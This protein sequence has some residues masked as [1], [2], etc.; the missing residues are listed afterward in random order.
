MGSAVRAFEGHDSLSLQLKENSDDANTQNIPFAEGERNDISSAIYGSIYAVDVD[1]T[2]PLAFGYDKH[3]YSLKNSEVSYSFLDG[4]N[5]GKLSKNSKPLAGFS[6]NEATKL[7]SESLIFGM[8]SLGRGSVV[9]IVDN[10]LYRG[11]W[12]NGKLWVINAV[13]H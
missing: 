3:Y 12:E 4:G 13:F 9:Y 7:Q 8:E 2:H 10:P 1:T 6:G 5:V 11:F